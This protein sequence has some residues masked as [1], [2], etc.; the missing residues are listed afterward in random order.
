MKKHKSKEL[1]AKPQMNDNTV[2]PFDLFHCKIRTKSRVNN[3]HI[4]GKFYIKIFKFLVKHSL[5]IFLI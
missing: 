1:S 5:K 4:L 2:K 3:F